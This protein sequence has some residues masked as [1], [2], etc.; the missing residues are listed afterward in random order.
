MTKLELAYNAGAV[1][2]AVLG[3]AAVMHDL[4]LVAG[5]LAFGTA[6]CMGGANQERRRHLRTLA[7][8]DWARRVAVG[9]QPRPLRPC[10]LLAGTSRGRAHQH[11][12]CTRNQ[13]AALTL[14]APIDCPARKDLTS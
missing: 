13:L 7:E 5:V 4:V 14:A 9:E 1:T 2:L 11:N 3:L 12:R 6:A 10:C 8:H